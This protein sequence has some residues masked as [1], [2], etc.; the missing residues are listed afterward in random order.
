MARIRAGMDT[1]LDLEGP[2]WRFALAI[3]GQPGVADACLM[4]QDRLGLDV[5]IL[6]FATYATTECS[7]TVTAQDIQAMDAAVQAWRTQAVMPLRALRRRLKQ[8]F[9]PPESEY[10]EMLRSK[11]KQTELL[12]EQIELA[13]LARWLGQRSGDWASEK[14]DLS[15]VL[16]RVIAH[17]AKGTYITQGADALDLDGAVS[18]LSLAAKSAKSTP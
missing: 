12:A 17:F 5:N 2:H 16:N 18:T 11:V 15:E 14:V 4:L 7:V 1:N 6:L 13:M 9:G 10:A 3:Y 8:G